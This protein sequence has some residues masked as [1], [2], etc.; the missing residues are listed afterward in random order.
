MNFAA[1]LKCFGTCVAA[2]PWWVWIVLPLAGAV[3]GALTYLAG[4]LLGGGGAIVVNALLKAILW[5]ALSGILAPF[6]YCLL[7]CVAKG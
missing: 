6:G 1:I 3:I 5:G 2:I 7:S 4:L